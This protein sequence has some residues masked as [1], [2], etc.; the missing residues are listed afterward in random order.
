[1]T[2]QPDGKIIIAGI[3]NGDWA[4]AQLNTDGQ[5]N[6]TFGTHYINVPGSNPDDAPNAVVLQ[7]D[8]K[9]VIAGSSSP[10][11][12][13]ITVVRLNSAA[14]RTILLAMSEWLSSTAYQAP[15]LPPESRLMPKIASSLLRILT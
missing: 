10:N 6:P 5:I 9:I 2:I 8:G 12:R 13:V 1:M 7:N 3:V 14:L 11:D 4:V 15:A